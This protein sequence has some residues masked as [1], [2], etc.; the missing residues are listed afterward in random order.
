M[1]DEHEHVWVRTGSSYGHIYYKCEC[2]AD[3]EECDCP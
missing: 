3:L 2:G 1:N